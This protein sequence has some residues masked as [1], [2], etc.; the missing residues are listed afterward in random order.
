MR[1]A[2]VNAMREAQSELKVA[3]SSFR[4]AAQLHAGSHVVKGL[5]K[6]IEAIEETQEFFEMLEDEE[7]NEE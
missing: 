4:K 3:A 5:A 7:D 6:T 2:V 1:K